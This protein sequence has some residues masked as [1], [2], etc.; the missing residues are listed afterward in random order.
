MCI[1]IH[2]PLLLPM[3]VGKRNAYAW[4]CG[5]DCAV[6]IW[7]SVC[8]PQ[9][10]ISTMVQHFMVPSLCSLCPISVGF[11]VWP[12]IIYCPF[13]A[14]DNTKYAFLSL[15]PSISFTLPPSCSLCL[16]VSLFRG[17]F[18]SR[19]LWITVCWLA[20]LAIS[21]SG[22]E[23]KMNKMATKNANKR[24]GRVQMVVCIQQQFIVK[25]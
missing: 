14:E 10:G 20:F 2:Y 23:A 15:Y 18:I 8:F 13:T 9:I 3:N 5:C 17:R 21:K 11:H 12:R 25:V 4:V 22:I 7:F 24:S 6:H 19:L 1:H 16:S